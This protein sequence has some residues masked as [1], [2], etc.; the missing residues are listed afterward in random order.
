MDKSKIE[1]CDSTFNP[2][3]GC[4]K[5]S[6]G[7]TNCYAES[8]MDKR[9]GKV[10]WGPQGERKRTSAALWNKPLL[11]QKQ[12]DSFME[13]PDCGWRGVAQSDGEGAYNVSCPVCWE[14]GGVGVELKLARRRVFC[15][16]LADVFEDR[17]ELVAWRVDLLRL[18][19][20]TP[21]LDWL[22]LTKRP[23]NILPMIADAGE[24]LLETGHRADGLQLLRWMKHGL[25][26]APANIWIGTTVEN[27]AAADKR[28]PELL[29]VPA[30]RRFLSCEPLLGPVNLD[31]HFGLLPGNRWAACLCD[32]I[33]PADRPC[34]T[35]E[36]RLALG[37]ASGIDWVI[38]GGES[39]QEARPARAAWFLSLRDQCQAAGIPFHFKQYGEWMDQEQ[40]TEPQYRMVADLD[41]D[42]FGGVRRFKKP[43][44]LLGGE[45]LY[46]IG[47]QHAG[48]RLDGM[49]WNQFPDTEQEDN[50]GKTDHNR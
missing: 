32:E 19:C 26:Y 47:K 3:L 36:G 41:P 14:N 37:E 6:A 34:L 10:Q 2:W 13:C 8:L 15:A 20:K 4:T 17:L 24:L 45:L 48:R 25:A 16:S 5:V 46:R 30:H 31:R 18:I 33:D 12:A 21:Q 50:D 49:E 44:L 1:W 39:G 11:W 40:M 7:C 27:Q 38:A 35:C 28:I 9:Y 23:E 29:K 22:L 42:A 43:S